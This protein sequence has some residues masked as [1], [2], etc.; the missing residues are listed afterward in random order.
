MS[1][2]FVWVINSRAF[3]ASK[4]AGGAKRASSMLIGSG[5]LANMTARKMTKEHAL[6]LGY[7]PLA[8]LLREQ[9]ER[10]AR[11]ET[12]RREQ[13][14][15]AADKAYAALKIVTGRHDLMSRLS[16]LEQQLI[17]EA[18]ASAVAANLK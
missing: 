4:S 10:A 9:H 11:A 16:R 3:V 5:S 13:A 1:I 14:Q 18:W 7:R 12:H 8:D 15:D 6:R 17:N 2:E